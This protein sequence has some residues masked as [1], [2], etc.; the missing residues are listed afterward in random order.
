MCLLYTLFQAHKLLLV[1]LKINLAVE[2]SLDVCLSF[3]Y[4]KLINSNK[5]YIKSGPVQENLIQ[6]L[7]SHKLKLLAAATITL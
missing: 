4:V 2:L 6:N 3:K 1:I 5:I 7:I